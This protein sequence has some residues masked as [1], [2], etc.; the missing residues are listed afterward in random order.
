MSKGASAGRLTKLAK[1][2]AAKRSAHKPDVKRT[3]TGKPVS[4]LDAAQALIREVLKFE[5]PTDSVLGAYFR[6]HR[7]W[8]S[9][10]RN[11]LGQVVFSV[12]RE[13]A[14]MKLL[15]R[16]AEG[17]SAIE[18]ERRLALLAWPTGDVERL[19]LDA[20]ALL[21]LTAAAA[22]DRSTFTEEAHLNTPQWLI[23]ALRLQVGD[24]THALLESL[25]AQ[26][27]LDLRANPL[28]AKRD[29][30]QRHLLAQGIDSM[31]TPFAPLG[32]RVVGKPSLAKSEVIS[33]GMVEVQDEGS[34]LLALL[35]DAKRGEMVG[36]FC[37]GG[38]GKTMALG[39]AMRNSGRLYAMDTSA[40]RL[41]VIA[42]RAQR[43]GLTNIYTMALEGVADERLLRLAGKLDRVLVDAPCSGLGTLRRSPELKWRYQP[44]DIAALAETQRGILAAAA[45]LVKPGGRL[46]YATCSLLREENEDV[47]ASF[48]TESGEFTSEDVFDVLSH[49]KVPQAASLVNNGTLRLWPH[50]HS[51]DGFFAAVLTRQ[52]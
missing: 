50:K 16:S 39:A 10:D 18:F 31:P 4:L 2:H 41:A 17:A 3:R 37:A 33:L 9:R 47:V 20:P 30:V 38:G 14:S 5:G 42:P 32:L 25:D 46:V 27:P 7:Q 26:A 1:Q 43:N 19:G 15:A 49:A 22:T 48:L 44:S 34:Q 8:G 12:V 45:K 28:K 11:A 51:T 35:V 36:D 24:D 40:S 52:R 6:E 23:D 13:L 29:D 21:W